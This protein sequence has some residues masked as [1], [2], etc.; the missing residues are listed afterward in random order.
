MFSYLCTRKIGRVSVGRAK[1]PVFEINLLFMEMLA[2]E[3]YLL[4]EDVLVL[5]SSYYH[6]E[7]K[8]NR[9]HRT[10][11]DG[12]IHPGRIVAPLCRCG[13]YQRR[14]VGSVVR[15]GDR[16]LCPLRPSLLRVFTN[17]PKCFRA[18]AGGCVPLPGAGKP[19]GD[20]SAGG[21]YPKAVR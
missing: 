15:S 4:E 8:G 20:L 9:I 21:E 5:Y 14:P 18:A 16:A 19:C 2:L 12:K 10:Q 3:K 7:G 11:R 17:Q 6:M 13:N 1:I